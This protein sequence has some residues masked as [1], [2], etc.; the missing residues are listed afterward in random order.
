MR[1]IFRQRSSPCIF[2]LGA[3]SECQCGAQLPAVV[4]LQHNGTFVFVCQNLS[5]VL[6]FLSVRLAAYLTSWQ[7]FFHNLI[8][9]FNCLWLS[10]G[11]VFL[12]QMTRIVHTTQGFQYTLD[13]VISYC[14][15]FPLTKDLTLFEGSLV[16]I[17]A[18][19]IWRFGF[20]ATFT[21]LVDL[22]SY[23]IAY[24]IIVRN[25]LFQHLKMGD[26]SLDMEMLFLKGY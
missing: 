6:S 14:F 23:E 21:S 5:L 15:S 25:L 2:P 19:S 20:V 13:L 24:P 10:S 18:F 17:T 16:E 4:K 22:S 9:F 3:G 26:S 12:R 11:S 7:K 8:T 1:L